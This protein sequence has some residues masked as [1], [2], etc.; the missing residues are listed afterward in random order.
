MHRRTLLG[1]LGSTAVLTAAGCLDR[2]GSGN[3][4]AETDT[5]EPVTETD[6]PSDTPAENPFQNDPCPSFSETVDRTVCWHT[7]DT[8]SEP[9]YMDAST[10]VFEPTP[11][12]SEVQS[13][14]FVL[15]NNSETTVGLNPHA[16]A[17]KRKTT[18]GWQHVAPD[19]SVEPWLHLESMQTYTWRLTSGPRTQ[20]N[21]ERTMALTQDLRAGTYAFQ[22]TGIEDT[23]SSS[24][25]SVECIV[26]FEVAPKNGT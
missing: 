3:S 18:D 24:G 2:G 23:E 25:T 17:I 9:I 11:N 5:D 19:A 8:E 21:A 4:P 26:L 22:I 13:I 20:A 14:E 6:D 10:A 12:S 16:W 1:T 7:A 15:H